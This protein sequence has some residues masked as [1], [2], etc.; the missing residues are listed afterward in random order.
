QTLR[1]LFQYKPQ[2]IDELMINTGDFIYVDPSQQS[3]VCEGW[4]IGTS[5]R[6]GCRGFLPENYTERA[7]ESDT[8]VKHREY[9]LTTTPRFLTRTKNEPNEKLNGEVLSSSM[10]RSL[11][12]ILPQQNS[13]LQRGVL[14][15]RHGERVDQ[16]FGKSWLQQCL[17]AEGKYYRADLNF[18]STLP[19]RKD[20]VSHFEYDPPL[21]CCG[22]FQ[23]RL[24]GEALLDH[25]VTVNYI[26]SSPALR[27]IQ[28]AQHVLQGLKLDNKVKIRVEPGL[29]EWTKWEASRVIP[30]FM[31]VTELAEA[32]YKI[33]TS[34][35]GNFSLS[36]LV[37]SESYEE[38]VSRSSAVI[39]QIITSCSSKGVILIVGHGSSLTSLTRPLIGLPARDSSDF[40]QVVRK[41][42]SLGVCFCEEVKE[43][44]KWQVANPPVTTLTHGANAAFNWRNVIVEH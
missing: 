40:A 4:V 41:I 18:P 9:V 31:T 32:S 6:T 43:E 16:V 33:D 12:N 2:N 29:F 30:N 36:S 39:K 14:V 8:W 34:Y 7:S 1:A 3:S 13:T 37:P 24:I 15:M 21:S 26:Y 23:S 27:C 19:K 10:S 38:Y 35:R 5:H 42:P 11:T 22:V 25:E 20:G 44:S 28:T 17:T